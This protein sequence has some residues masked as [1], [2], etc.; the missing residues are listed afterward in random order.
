MSYYDTCSAHVYVDPSLCVLSLKMMEETAYSTRYI[1]GRNCGNFSST[2]KKMAPSS[3]MRNETQKMVRGRA[4][5]HDMLSFWEPFNRQ[6]LTWISDH[7]FST[8]GRSWERGTAPGV[9]VGMQLWVAM[10][11]HMALLEARSTSGG[12]RQLSPMVAPELLCLLPHPKWR[13]R[14]STWHIGQMEKC[15]AR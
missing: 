11:R 2:R 10:Q 4:D 1:H 3:C 13:Q 6:V 7:G 5:S 9:E 8:R 15:V 12:R 14:G